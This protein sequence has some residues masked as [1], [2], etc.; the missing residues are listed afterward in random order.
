DGDHQVLRH[1]QEQHPVRRLLSGDLIV[2]TVIVKAAAHP[3]SGFFL[4]SVKR[5]S[6][7]CGGAHLNM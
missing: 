5:M 6:T 1:H 3:R 4:L 7:A 2:L